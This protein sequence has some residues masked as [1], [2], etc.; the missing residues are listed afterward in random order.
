MYPDSRGSLDSMDCA[1]LPR[2]STSDDPFLTAAAV[3]VC[4]EME[5][6]LQY[7]DVVENISSAFCHTSSLMSIYSMRH[8]NGIMIESIISKFSAH[9]L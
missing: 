7:G 1:R 9:A 5:I 4:S 2:S 3:V 6:A 8:M